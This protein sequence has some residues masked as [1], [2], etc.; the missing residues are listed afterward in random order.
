MGRCWVEIFWKEYKEE[1]EKEEEKWREGEGE[2]EMV[3]LLS[4]DWV[5]KLRGFR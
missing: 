2:V 3:F 1:E 5:L 4:M